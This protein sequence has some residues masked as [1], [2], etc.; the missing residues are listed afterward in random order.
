M[1]RL[2]VSWQNGRKERI[3]PS[4][5]NDDG[6]KTKTETENQK[7]FDDLKTCFILDRFLVL[8]SKRKV[9]INCTVSLDSGGVMIFSTCQLFGG[10]YGNKKGCL[11]GTVAG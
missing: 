10:H 6:T 2:M 8:T 4:Y 9:K 7:I 1:K 3:F 11:V 5:S